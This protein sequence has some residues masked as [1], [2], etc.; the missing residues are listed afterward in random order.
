MSF[1]FEIQSTRVISTLCRERGLK[2]FIS[3][4]FF[5]RGLPYRRNKDKSD[6]AILFKENCGTCSTKHAALRQLAIENK[7]TKV[8][9]MLGIFEM[10]KINTPAVALTLN[11][12]GL[13]YIPEAHNY[14]RIDSQIMDYT[15]PSFSS[16]N[17]IADLMEEQE[18]TPGQVTEYKI[19]YHRAF[20]QNWIS[21]QPSFA[22]SLEELWKIREKCIFALY[23]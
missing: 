9:L 8:I 4:A 16:N 14:L 19:K 2:D 5:I 3:A 1:N 7:I 18:I 22:Y 13:S 17:F 10:N 20:L 12:Y 11:K 21:R 6:I 15:K 23:T